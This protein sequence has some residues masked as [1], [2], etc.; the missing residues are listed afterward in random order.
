MDLIQYGQLFNEGMVGMD[1]LF[2]DMKESKKHFSKKKYPVFFENMMNK[3]DRV[4]NAIEEVYNYERN[5]DKWLFRLAE[6]FV[7]YAQRMIQSETRKFKRDNL[8]IDC[9]I[10]VVSYVIPAILEYKGNMSEPFAEKILEE[11]NKTF[12]TRMAGGNYEMILSGFNTNIFGIS[13][14]K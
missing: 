2:E 8:Q 14:G 12:G 10:Y 6:R 3:Y 5:K 1:A 7:G 4:F 9:N 11:W 13:F